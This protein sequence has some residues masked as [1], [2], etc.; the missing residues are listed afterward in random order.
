MSDPVVAA[1]R[2]K[3]LLPW[4]LSF[5]RPYRGRVVLLTFLLV[6]EIA[7]GALQP[8][9]LSIV[10]DY[11]LGDRP[12]PAWIAPWMMSITNGHKLAFW[13]RW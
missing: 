8:W 11:V 13:S 7:L 10:I 4:T 12:W 3:P 2:Q 1:S 9:P 6:T 5:L